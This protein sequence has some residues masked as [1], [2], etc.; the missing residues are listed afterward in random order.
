MF[1]RPDAASRRERVLLK[2]IETQAQTIRDLNDR[3]MYATG[4]AWTLPDLPENTQPVADYVPPAW[5]AS[6]EQESVF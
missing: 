6:P 2:I 3:L 4:H 5:T 1:S